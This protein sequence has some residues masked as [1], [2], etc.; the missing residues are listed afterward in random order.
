M[1]EFICTDCGH[2]VHTESDE[3]FNMPWSDGHRCRFREV[4]EGP[5]DPLKG[6]EEFHTGGG[7]MALQKDTVLGYI[8]IT[9]SD[10]C[11]MPKA[12]QECTIGFYDNESNAI[13]Y[14]RAPFDL[15]KGGAVRISH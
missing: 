1:R 14:V 5:P 2:N 6:F 10:G 12:G 9:D 3:P 15:V 11:D 13:G 8:M 4:K 7:C